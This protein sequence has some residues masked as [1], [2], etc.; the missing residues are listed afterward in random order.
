MK[1]NKPPQRETVACDVKP[2]REKLKVKGDR[3]QDEQDDRAEDPRV[4]P[5]ERR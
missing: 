5:I 4:E 2:N 3:R 1:E